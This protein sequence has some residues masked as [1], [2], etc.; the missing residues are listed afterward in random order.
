[1]KTDVY[2]AKRLGQKNTSNY[3]ISSSKYNR[4]SSEDI[5][6][7]KGISQAAKRGNTKFSPLKCIRKIEE[8]ISLEYILETSQ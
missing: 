1:M 3:T 6:Q 7:L 4:S 2:A 8:E 5:S